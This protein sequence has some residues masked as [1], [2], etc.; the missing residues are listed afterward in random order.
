MFTFSDSISNSD[1]G[2]GKAVKPLIVDCKGYLYRFQG[3]V[4]ETAM[5]CS[6]SGSWT[7]C[8][9]SSTS[10][11]GV[12]GLIRRLRGVLLSVLITAPFCSGFGASRG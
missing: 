5:L 4:S 8:G 3:F 2:A 11:G 12:G 6:F 10:A 7:G 1:A 9:A